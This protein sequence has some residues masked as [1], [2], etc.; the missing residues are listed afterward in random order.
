MSVR[1]STSFQARSIHTWAP[2]RIYRVELSDRAM[3]FLR[4]GGQFDLD[5]GRPS[6]VPGQGAAVM[7]LAAGEALF[8][9]HKK[10]EYIARDPNQ[11]PEAVLG[12][13]P[14]NFKL[15]PA[16]IQNA[17]LLPKKWLL[18]FV[19]QHHGRMV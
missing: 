4:I 17:S 11:D 9:N 15:T 18:S 10:E 7:I 5:R 2:D 1:P 13:H 12:I 3:Y 19:R 16:D 6:G 14:H 8:R